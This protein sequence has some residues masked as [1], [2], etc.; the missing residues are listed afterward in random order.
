VAADSD[1]SSGTL[2]GVVPA[3]GISAPPP[4]VM[5][6]PTADG[7]R[8]YYTVK[9][10]QGPT[11]VSSEQLVDSIRAG[12]ITRNERIW[13]EN[14]PDWISVAESQFASEFVSSS[15]RSTSGLAVLSAALGSAGYLLLML[16]TVL[17]VLET[18]RQHITVS[19]NIGI[20]AMVAVD[21]I[22]GIVAVLLGHLAIQNFR[23]VPGRPQERYAIVVGL[24]CGYTAMV[25]S[26]L[27]GVATAVSSSGASSEVAWIIGVQGLLG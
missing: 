5:E 22:V 19:D 9:G 26:I 15:D 3:S 25:I 13:R 17:L 27:L 7:E 11:P 8:W 24:S 18:R 23:R 20:L 1:A 12:T 6:P 4:P 2:A 21:F 16:C 14:L 10:K